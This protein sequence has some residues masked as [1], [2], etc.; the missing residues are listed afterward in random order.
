MPK[1]NPEFQKFPTDKRKYD[2]GYLRVF[3]KI[4]P[5][6]NGGGFRSD[7]MSGCDPYIVCGTCDGIGFI[8]K[9]KCSYCEGKGYF[10]DK[11][12]HGN[13]IKTSCINC[14]GVGKI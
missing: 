1:S 6:C 3:G 12:V 7:L 5:H 11:T 9:E 13:D 10:M 2:Q 14:Q 4:C 8:P